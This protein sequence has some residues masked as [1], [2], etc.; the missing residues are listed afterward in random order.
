MN[1][2]NKLAIV[3]LA[4]GMTQMVGYICG[5]KVLRGIGLASG[6][7][8]FPKVFSEADG[9]E[10]F[11]ANFVLV[12]TEAD[13]SEWRC[14]LDPEAYSR[15]EGPYNRR[16][17]YGATL[18]F[19]PRLPEDLRKSLISGALAPGSLMREEMDVPTSVEDLKIVVTPRDGEA[20]GPWVFNMNGELLRKELRP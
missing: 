9:Y 12:G 16:N 15:I 3:V 20:E 4:I 7:A 2:S 18:A 6:V 14:E 8:P 11:A 1:T 17:V 5:S 19:A 10:A 13:G